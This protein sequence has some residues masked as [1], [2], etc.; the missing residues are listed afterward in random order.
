ML[1]A[2]FAQ[3]LAFG[4]H[5]RFHD[6][7]SIGEDAHRME[8]LVKFAASAGAAA[9]LIVGAGGAMA[10]TAAP[11]AHPAA[12]APAAKA[13]PAAARSHRRGKVGELARLGGHPNLN[14]IWQVMNGANW[15]LEPHDAQQANAD[16]AELGAIGA[17]PGGLGVVEGGTIPYLPAAVAQ[18]DANHAAAPKADPEAACYLPGIPR[19]TY[20]DHP[21]Q[22]IQGANGDMLM[23]Y[24]YDSANRTI[25]MQ[26]TGEPP[27]DTW[28]GTSY[29]HWEGDTLVVTTLGQNG[30]SWLDRK[31]DYMQEGANKVVERFTLKDHDHLKYEATIEDPM[32]FS[33][34]WKIS[35]ILYRHVEPNAE[36]LDFR[37]VPFAD[38][39]VYGDVLKDDAKPK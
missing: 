39:L 19:A 10:A 28:M 27:I 32:T 25:Y 34:P 15:D 35:M 23:A 33:R 24:E 17:E 14:G 36:L 38:L 2:A 16:P 22:I 8:G 4:S 6:K 20:M 12:K 21:F 31:G 7:R 29:G 3:L 13:A 1:A 37:C 26:P 5:I 30:M 18:R 11:A 9:M